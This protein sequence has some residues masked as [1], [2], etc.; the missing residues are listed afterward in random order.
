[1]NRHAK[2]K[3]LF[4]SL[5]HRNLKSI[6]Y[7]MLYLVLILQRGQRCVACVVDV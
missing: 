3:W 1:M 4:H 5:K 7:V 2:D 6:I